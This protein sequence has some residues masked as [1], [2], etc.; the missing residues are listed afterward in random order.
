MMQNINAKT[1]VLLVEDDEEDYLLT[2][3][4]LAEGGH[5]KF[6]LDWASTFEAGS[7]AIARRAHDV[8]L[9]DYHLGA[10]SG[11]DLLRQTFAVDSRVPAIMLTGQGNPELDETLMKAGAA[12]YLVKGRFDAAT[13]ERSIRYALERRLAETVLRQA[14]GELE[15]RVQERTRELRAAL[16]SLTQEIQE[17]RRAENAVQRL[18]QEL[19]HVGRVSVIGQLA[20][21]LAH[22][23]SQPLTAIMTNTQAALDLLGPGVVDVAEVSDILADILADDQRAREVIQRLRNLLKKTPLEMQRLDVNDLV[24]EVMRLLRGDALA[25]EVAITLELVPGLPT[26]N[27]DRIQLQQVL[28]NLVVNAFQAM[29]SVPAGA[30]KLVVRTQQT[31]PGVV[32]VAVQDSGVGIPPDKLEAVFEPFFTTKTGG[33]GMGLSICHTI[34]ESH[35]GRVW[36][37]NNATRGATVQFTLPALVE[38]RP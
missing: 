34:V 38:D 20:A 36:A 15:W 12:D 9:I 11:S 33:M 32:Q 14:Y 37:T 28:L 8:Y 25:R 18:N 29:E 23:L 5:G 10:G 6:E 27:G 13:L 31:E 22:E 30:R 3:D 21:T 19:A 4:L 1:H 26:V 24:P 16:D 17:R 35:Q 2:R 7:E